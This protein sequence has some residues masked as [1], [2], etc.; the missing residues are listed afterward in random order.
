MLPCTEE[1][2]VLAYFILFLIYTSLS[3]LF[4]PSR[5][6][7]LTSR[8]Y[9]V[10]EWHKRSLRVNTRLQ[11]ESAI[12]TIQYINNFHNFGE[13]KFYLKSHVRVLRSLHIMRY[14]LYIV[15]EYINYNNAHSQL[16]SGQLNWWPGLRSKSPH[17]RW[18]K[19]L[20]STIWIIYSRA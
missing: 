2:V 7:F 1:E 10:W 9:T 3:T 6:P 17:I 18:S 4:G 16:Q 8:R 14:K 20:L 19:W 15:C 12:N 5:S 13:Q 11:R